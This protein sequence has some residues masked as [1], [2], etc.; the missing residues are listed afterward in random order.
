MFLACANMLF[1]LR[2]APVRHPQENN[3]FSEETAMYFLKI[4]LKRKT[5]HSAYIPFYFLFL[6]RTCFN[7]KNLYL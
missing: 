7:F 5:E 6:F 2:R 4:F 3:L 1:C